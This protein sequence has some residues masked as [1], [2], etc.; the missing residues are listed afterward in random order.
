MNE[1]GASVIQRRL[2]AFRLGV[3]GHAADIPGPHCGAGLGLD[4]E[5]VG[6]DAVQFQFQTQ[7]VQIHRAE[8]DTPRRRHHQGAGGSGCASHADR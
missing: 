1:V 2:L 3:I 7:P 6:L 5:A 4:R 8:G